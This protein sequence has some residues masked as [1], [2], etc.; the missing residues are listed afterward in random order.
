MTPH[1]VSRNY[2]RHQH[3]EL[4]FILRTIDLGGHVIKPSFSSFMRL[5]W[6]LLSDKTPL[7]YKYTSDNRVTYTLSYIDR[8]LISFVRIDTICSTMALFNQ[9]VPFMTRDDLYDQT[10]EMICLGS[11]PA[12]NECTIQ[13]QRHVIFGKVTA[14]VYFDFYNDHPN[15]TPYA[16]RIIMNC[17]KTDWCIAREGL[18]KT[19]GWKFVD[20]KRTLELTKCSDITG[21]SW[22]GENDEYFV[23]TNKKNDTKISIFEQLRENTLVICL[24]GMKG[25]F[26]VTNVY[27]YA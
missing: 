6:N 18:G 17:K 9:S 23:S 14:R 19:V 13:L 16:I 2:N 27:H 24:H 1:Y 22:I 8:K 4:S 20:G 7:E 3:I 12:K 11:Y 26:G 21:G 15:F 25:K 5:Y 10:G